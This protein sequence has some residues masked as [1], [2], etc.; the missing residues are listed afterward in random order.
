MNFIFMTVPPFGKGVAE[1]SNEEI[2]L[3]RLVTVMVCMAVML[4]AGGARYAYAGP[5]MGG[6]ADSEQKLKDRPDTKPLKCL[7]PINMSGGTVLPKGKVT[8]CVKYKYVHKDE[9]YDGSER[10]TGNYGGKYDR[11]NQQVQLTA[12][13]GLFEN[14]DARIMVPFWDKEFKRKAGNP[15][16]HADT[17]SVSGLGD[18]VVMGR[19]ALM[20][21]RKGD[22]INL[23]FGAGLKM[24]TGDADRQNG[25][26]FSNTHKYLGPGAQL[27]TGSWDPKFELGA[28]KFLGRS[29]LD[30]H[31]MYTLPGEGSHGSRKGNQFKYNF[32][33]GYALNKLFDLEIE[34]NGVD[35][36]RH[37]YDHSMTVN[38]GGHTIYLTPGVHWKITDKCHFSVGAPIVIYRNLNGD[39]ANPERNGKYALGESFQVI[40]RLGYS[41]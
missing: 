26:P 17:D 4:L 28:T 15:P 32:G 13:A 37:K 18:V 3:K 40:G 22:W 39:H 35:Q 23:A 7:G 16:V 19:Y 2:V 5:V 12:K 6:G 34:L 8:A 36:A 41:F 9:L 27:G 33:Y 14:F 11:V 20:S 10:M 25:P 31:F 30:A 24:P 21:Q 29:R 38:T 1:K